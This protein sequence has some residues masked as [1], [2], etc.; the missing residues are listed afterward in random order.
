MA[1]PVFDITIC[2]H[3]SDS[4]VLVNGEDVSSSIR[5]IR[6]DQAVGE[7]PSVLIELVG[8]AARVRVTAAIDKESLFLNGGAPLETAVAEAPIETRAEGEN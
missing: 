3:S 1:D 6:V 2:K 7:C 4:R 8:T 5:R